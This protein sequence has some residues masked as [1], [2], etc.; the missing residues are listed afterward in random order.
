MT[1]DVDAILVKWADG[2][3]RSDADAIAALYTPDAIFIGGIGGLNLG[4]DGVRGYFQANVSN[5]TIVFRDVTVRPQGDDVVVVAMIGA[6][7]RDG[8]ESRDFR[9]LQ[10][11]VRTPDGWRIAAHHGSHGL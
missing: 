7:V 4:Q 11:Q 8:G 6:I 9:F 1:A 5:S 10:T 3:G 2:F